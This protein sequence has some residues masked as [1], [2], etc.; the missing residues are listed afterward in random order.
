VGL[1]GEDEYEVVKV[2]AILG[3]GV[4]FCD[5]EGWTSLVKP[6]FLICE[7]DEVLLL[8]F[9]PT[10]E[11]INAVKAV[12]SEV[13]ELK[14]IGE[15]SKLKGTDQNTI[16]QHLRMM[17]GLVEPFEFPATG[18]WTIAEVEFEG[19]GGFLED[20]WRIKVDIGVPTLD[21]S[22]ECLVRC[23]EIDETG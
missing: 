11:L 13:D 19:K 3:A 9:P 14:E 23:S 17:A 22:A 10:N 1:G 15:E 18:V 4:Y 2:V 16:S 8:L 6:I 21:L 20:G 12:R 5:W 7:S